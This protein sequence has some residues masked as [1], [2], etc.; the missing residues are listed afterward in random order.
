M[1]KLFGTDGIRG[2]ANEY[3]MT[4]EMAVRVGRAVVS[5]FARAGQPRKSSLARIPDYRAT[6]WN[7]GLWPASVLPAKSYLGDALPTPGV[8]FLTSHSRP[9]PASSF[10]LPTTRILTTELSFSMGTAANCATRMKPKLKN[11]SWGNHCSLCAETRCSQRL[12]T[13]HIICIRPGLI[14]ARFLKAPWPAEEPFKGLKIALDC[15]NGATF[16]IAPEL[17]AELGA[18]VIPLVDSSQRHQY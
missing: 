17:F 1:K 14:T 2:V 10:Q 11:G 4:A 15:S 5:Y 13:V 16:L 6:C 8:A 12:G 7:P 9:T 18:E 3:P